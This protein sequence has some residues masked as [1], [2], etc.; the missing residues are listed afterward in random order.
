MAIAMFLKVLAVEGVATPVG[1][2]HPLDPGLR[3]F[4]KAWPV[5]VDEL[6]MMKRTGTTAEAPA[7]ELSE[8][9]WADACIVDLGRN[10]VPKVPLANNV[11]VWSRTMAVSV[12]NAVTLTRSS[13]PRD[14][15]IEQPGLVL[16]WKVFC[17]CVTEDD[18]VV[19][20]IGPKPCPGR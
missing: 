20:I 19:V 11:L 12:D 17:A 13:A 5:V 10:E 7:S 8:P 4:T 1:V 16:S 14:I 15:V 2:N 9:V 3:P 6:W 18:T